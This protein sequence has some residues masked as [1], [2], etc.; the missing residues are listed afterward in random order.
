MV[1]TAEKILQFL[2]EMDKDSEYKYRSNIEASALG[3]KGFA[4]TKLKK[5]DEAIPPLSR[6]Y[7]LRVNNKKDVA[8]I[9]ENKMGAEAISDNRE[10]IVVEKTLAKCCQLRGQD[11]PLPPLTKFSRTTHLFNT[12]GTAVSSD[13]LVA[14]KGEYSRLADGSTTVIVEEKVDGANF[15]FSLSSSGE[16]LSQNRSRYVSPGDHAQFSPLAAW[17]EEHREALTTVLNSHGEI[18]RTASQG[19]ILFGEWVVARHSIAYHQLPSHFVAFDIYDRLHKRF[20]S[21]SR[22]HS[23]LKGSSIPVVPVITTRT[24]GKNYVN[25]VK[26]LIETPSKFRTDGGPVEGIILRSDE[27]KWLEHRVKIVRPDFVAGCNDG[28]WLSRDIDK[29]RVDRE[30]ALTYL[31]G[32][33]P[34][35]VSSVDQ[36]SSSSED[37]PTAST[38]DES[39]S[40]VSKGMIIPESK[41][42][43]KLS[44]KEAK[45]LKEQLT[46]KAKLRRKAPKNV[47]MMG[48]P[49]SGKSTF[50]LKLASEW[51]RQNDEKKSMNNNNSGNIMKNED[52]FVVINQDK[53]GRKACVELASKTSGKGRVV[54]DRCNPTSSERSEWMD[55][56]HNSYNQTALV[57]FAT[58]E[59]TCIERAAKRVGHETIPEGRGQ[60]IIQDMGKR[61]EPPTSAERKLFSAVY[62]VNSDEDS[63]AILSR[64]GC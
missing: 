26:R 37:T 40:P 62:V 45:I 42:Q 64:W 32:C 24:F 60:R 28:H 2:D 6:S 14:T 43:V 33:Y 57:Y 27:P 58:A 34:C 39:L 8:A 50:S 36:D 61:F 25:E 41:P 30:F 49:A 54:L 5:I 31:E 56:L 46:A 53:M 17:V 22:F 23:I 51:Q 52:V 55:I 10:F 9:D 35:A 15:G 59:T 16:I 63:D 4:L 7:E 13:D 47:M 44:K 20:Y 48:L 1:H 18:D 21:R 38:P 12:G 3:Y 11:S 29:Q 19:L